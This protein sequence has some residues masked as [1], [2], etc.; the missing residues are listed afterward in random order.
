MNMGEDRLGMLQYFLEDFELL[1]IA[2][3]MALAHCVSVPMENEIMLKYGVVTTPAGEVPV[4]LYNDSTYINNARVLQS[5][6]FQDRM[7]NEYTDS[8]GNV[9]G[10]EE[11][12]GKVCLVYEVD[13]MVCSEE[14]WEKLFECWQAKSG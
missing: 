11:G 6:R 3:K 12:G 7:V 4:S 5:F 8:K 13:G 9:L 14:M 2:Q 1:G 10:S